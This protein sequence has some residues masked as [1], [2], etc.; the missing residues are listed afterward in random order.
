MPSQRI[1]LYFLQSL[2]HTESLVTLSW[3]WT[4]SCNWHNFF[5]QNVESRHITITDH[6]NNMSKTVLVRFTKFLML[7][8]CPDQYTTFEISF[9]QI[10]KLEP[11]QNN[12]QSLNNFGWLFVFV[13]YLDLFW[14][15]L[16]Y[17]RCMTAKSTPTPRWCV[18]RQGRHEQGSIPWLPWRRFLARSLSRRSGSVCWV[19]Y[20]LFSDSLS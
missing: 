4:F 6:R 12:F 2:F 13:V 16:V 5:L 20:M 18:G 14:M 19:V 1:M 3:C 9:I 11:V 7:A 15:I 17:D 10:R 8:W